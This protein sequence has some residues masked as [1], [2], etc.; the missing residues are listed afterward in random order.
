MLW[1]AVAT[2]RRTAVYV[3][4]K[5]TEGYIFHKGG[6]VEEFVRTNFLHAAN[7]A[8]RDPTALVIYDGDGDAPIGAV[9][10]PPHAKATTVVVSSPKSA[11]YKEFV[12]EG[13]LRLCFPVFSSNEMSDLLNSCFKDLQ[14]KDA[15]GM[16]E[17]YLRWG[18]IPRYVLTRLDEDSQMT[19][20]TALPKVNLDWL[21]D[22][23]CS[24]DIEGDAAVSHRLFHLKPRG[25]TDT[26]FVGGRS[27]S[28][29]FLVRTDL[30][31]KYAAE[32]VYKALKQRGTR[33]IAELLAQPTQSAQLSKF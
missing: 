26:G 22:V 27:L 2:Q 4:D 9:G 8:M 1:H 30:S 11:R 29:Y 32:V 13:G 17:R 21:A 3:S 12:R 6:H 25:E 16:Q 31:S 20:D 7:T 5:A 15:A 33:R 24:G 19:L 10:R 28:S 14:A 18:G 23:I